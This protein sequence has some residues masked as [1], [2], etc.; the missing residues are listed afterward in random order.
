[1][2]EFDQWKWDLRWIGSDGMDTADPWQCWDDSWEPRDCY[3]R[4]C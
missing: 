4:V 3:R 2:L 1:M